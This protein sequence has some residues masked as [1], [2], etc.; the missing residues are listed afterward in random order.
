[1]KRLATSLFLLLVIGLVA[2]ASAQPPCR[3]ATIPLPGTPLQV[4]TPPFQVF[5]DEIGQ[6]R[7][8]IPF[9]VFPGDVVLV[10]GDQGLADLQSCLYYNQGVIDP[11]T[12]SD[13]LHIDNNAVVPSEATLYSDCEPGNPND[14]CLPPF[15]IPFP[16]VYTG[17][18]QLVNPVFIAENTTGPTPYY[19]I[20]GAPYAYFVD[21]DPVETTS[22]PGCPSHPGP[23]NFRLFEDCHAIKI[24]STGVAT[25]LDCVTQDPVTGCPAFLLDGTVAFSPGWVRIHE[26]AFSAP[27][28]DQLHFFG[29]HFVSFCSDPVETPA[30]VPEAA[31]V[32]IRPIPP[33]DPDPIVDIIED[34]TPIVYGCGSARYEIFSDPPEPTAVPKTTW[35][36]LKTLYR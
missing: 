31:D 6:Q 20:P 32:G 3:P 1:M 15:E 21:S 25:T 27:V 35:G 17:A 30:E 9:P 24:D 13:V 14:P 26:G 34:T 4:P 18:A 10:D 22:Q 23:L 36:K 29:N 16:T 33:G 8:P 12:W 7:A 28:S 19:P 2:P 5:V 11:H